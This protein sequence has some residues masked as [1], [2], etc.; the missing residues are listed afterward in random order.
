M[1]KC[2]MMKF[3]MIVNEKKQLLFN[4]SLI[5]YLSIFIIL[6]IYQQMIFFIFFHFFNI[7][8]YGF[9]I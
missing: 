8:Y 5:N 4:K 1:K 9:N 6:L 2:M 7:K 3:K